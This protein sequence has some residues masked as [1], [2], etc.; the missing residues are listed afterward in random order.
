MFLRKDGIYMSNCNVLHAIT[1]MLIAT[2]ART[3]KIILN[4]SFQYEKNY[5]SFKCF[6]TVFTS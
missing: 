6:R 3:T 4:M 5:I 1:I 2:A